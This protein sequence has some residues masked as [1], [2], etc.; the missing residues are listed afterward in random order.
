MM[1]MILLK[2]LTAHAMLIVS[3]C[4]SENRIMKQYH[5]DSLAE[6]IP[7]RWTFILKVFRN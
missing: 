7:G 1:N 5:Q 4:S 6:T 3:A 2:K